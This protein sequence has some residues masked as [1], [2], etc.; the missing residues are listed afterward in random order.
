MIK[1]GFLFVL[2]SVLFIASVLSVPSGLDAWDCVQDNC[3]VPLAFEE[4]E[5]YKQY[6]FFDS[7]IH[8]YSRN[9]S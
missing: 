9:E 1:G 3:F 7:C 2:F 4:S 6:K 5:L 8:N